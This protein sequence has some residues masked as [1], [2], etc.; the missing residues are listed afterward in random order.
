VAPALNVWL[1]QKVALRGV[2][3]EFGTNSKYIAWLRQAEI[4]ICKPDD[5]RSARADGAAGR[6]RAGTISAGRWREV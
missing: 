4:R 3:I 2:P 1:A 6:H 5:Y